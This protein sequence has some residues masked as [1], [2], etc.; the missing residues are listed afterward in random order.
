MSKLAQTRDIATQRTRVSVKIVIERSIIVHACE[1]FGGGV[2]LLADLKARDVLFDRGDIDTGHGEMEACLLQKW[3]SVIGKILDQR[4]HG[5]VRIGAQ[6]I[7]GLVRGG[8]PR[9]GLGQQ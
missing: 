4:A 8:D 7:E 1:A 9:L 6:R 5:R 3:S 2:A